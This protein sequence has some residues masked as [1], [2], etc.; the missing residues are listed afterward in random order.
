MK[1][2]KVIQSPYV[3]LQNTSTSIEDRKKVVRRKYEMLGLESPPQTIENAK[4]S[5]LIHIM[6]AHVVSDKD[7][8]RAMVAR[9]VGT[10]SRALIMP[11]SPAVRDAMPPLVGKT[12]TLT[13]TPFKRPKVTHKFT[14]ASLQDVESW[15]GVAEGAAV[16]AGAVVVGFKTPALTPTRPLGLPTPNVTVVHEEDFFGLC[17]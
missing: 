17:S 14:A 12:P 2:K 8:L 10:A 9:V 5:I 3:K 7:Y 15:L 4:Y 6:C 16:V 13:V 11:P 1:S